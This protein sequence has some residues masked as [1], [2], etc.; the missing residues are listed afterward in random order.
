MKENS[1]ESPD[2]LFQGPFEA[3][4]C[5]DNCFEIVDGNGNVAIWVV[6]RTRAAAI[7]S[8]LNSTG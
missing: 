3:Q 1:D 6:G 4:P 5:S 8:L 2:E 7:V